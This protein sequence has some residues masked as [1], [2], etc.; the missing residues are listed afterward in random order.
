MSLSPYIWY[1]TLHFTG[2]SETFAPFVTGREP[3]RQDLCP[4][5]DPFDLYFDTSHLI[6]EVFGRD[7]SGPFSLC[8]S[9]TLR[10]SVPRRPDGP[11]RSAL[12]SLWLRVPVCRHG[13]APLLDA[14]HYEFHF[15]ANKSA[16][17]QTFLSFD[18]FNDL[19]HS[20]PFGFNRV[21]HDQSHAQ[22]GAMCPTLRQDLSGS[23]APFLTDLEPF[24][25]ARQKSGEDRALFLLC[26]PGASSVA[27]GNCS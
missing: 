21:R 16:F 2:F 5:T 6:W 15:D 26:L 3:F 18:W 10:T 9:A 1:H 13:W 4:V 20:K 14:T 17:L 24:Q 23:A 7:L 25:A 22:S 12:P 19:K 27:L 8:L 11:R